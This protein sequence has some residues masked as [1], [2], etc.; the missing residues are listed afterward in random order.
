M[1]K[2]NV[3][4]SKDDLLDA[5]AIIINTL[6]NVIMD[7]DQIPNEART[8]DKLSEHAKKVLLKTHATRSVHPK[9]K[10]LS[11]DLLHYYLYEIGERESAAFDYPQ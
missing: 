5:Q 3:T 6:C 8:S 7:V 2:L 9:L 4:A 11:L 1:G 10:S